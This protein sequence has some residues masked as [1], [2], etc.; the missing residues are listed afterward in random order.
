MRHLTFFLEALPSPPRHWLLYLW[1]LYPPF[2]GAGIRIHE[3]APDLSSISVSLRLRWW[4]RNYIGTIF[5]GSIYSMCDPFHM[6][7]L[8]ELLGPNYLVRDKGAEIR[9][10]KKGTGLLKAQFGVSSKVIAEIWN[11]PEDV[12]ER[13]FLAQVKN[14]EGEVVAE[15]TKVLHIRRKSAAPT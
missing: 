15:V 3:I 2:L 12:Q 11:S 10:L 14:D 4:N 1:N 6:V 8:L 13:R 7:I 9:F 5:G